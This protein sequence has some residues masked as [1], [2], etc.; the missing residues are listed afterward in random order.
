MRVG[1]KNQFPI[2]FPDILLNHL[3][4]S[5]TSRITAPGTLFGQLHL[6]PAPVSKINKI[7]WYV[8]K[9]YKFT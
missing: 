2:K 9:Y 8:R 3:D 5:A 4:H 1:I 6:R 7:I